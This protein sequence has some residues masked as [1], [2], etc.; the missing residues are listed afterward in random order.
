MKDNLIFEKYNCIGI[1]GGTFNPI[2]RGHLMLAQKTIE[3]F[4]EIEKIVI[5][6]N[7]KPAYKGNN[8]II[9][10]KERINMIKLAIKEF[11]F[12]EVSD[13]EIKRGGIT[14]SYDTLTEIKK[15]NPDLKIY[16]IIGADSL[17]TIDKWYK[18]DEFMKMCTLLAARRKSNYDEMKMYANNLM[19]KNKKAKIEF[20]NSPNMDISSSA[21]RKFLSRYESK[22]YSA[23]RERIDVYLDKRVTKEQKEFIL[24]NKL[25]FKNW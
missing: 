21:I 10:P 1:L 22:D 2:H 15:I 18:Y 7:N 14:Y 9:S 8:E 16:F 11:P 13:I 20:I 6:P 17:F 5:L 19:K 23:N 25:Y 12:A 4:P 3:Q 24:K